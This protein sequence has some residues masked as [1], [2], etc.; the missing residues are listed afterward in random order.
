ME[1][2]LYKINQEIQEVL[3]NAV[4]PETGEIRP[5]AEAELEML[6]QDK[7]QK[8]YHIG[9][10]F[11]DAEAYIERCKAE[12]KRIRTMRQSVEKRL[13]WLKTQ[14]LPANLTDKI[15][16]PELK[17]SSRKSESVEIGPFADLKKIRAADK[18]LVREKVELIPDKRAIKEYIKRTNM[19]FEDVRIVPKTTITVR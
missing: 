13:N 17:M 18:D 4:D 6:E 3:D 14:Y 7:L 10:Y 2:S 19:S 8:L 9:L 16:K 11:K 15:D 1:L 5:T 12:E